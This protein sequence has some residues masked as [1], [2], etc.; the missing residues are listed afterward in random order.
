MH[1]NEHCKYYILILFSLELVF[2]SLCEYVCTHVEYL[3][4]CLGG[5]YLYFHFSFDQQ[6]LFGKSLSSRQLPINNSQNYS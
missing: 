5:S 2:S 4:E 6:C 1:G 3:G